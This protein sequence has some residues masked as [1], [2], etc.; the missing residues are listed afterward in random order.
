LV[1]D[2]FS[3]KNF[4]GVNPSALVTG[5]PFIFSIC[6]A[7]SANTKVPLVVNA[8]KCPFQYFSDANDRALITNEPF[9]YSIFLP[10]VAHTKV[11]WVLN[12]LGDQ[13]SMATF[14]K[15]PMPVHW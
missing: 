12:V 8:L 9:A 11:L 10:L 15:M 3:E 6:F 7:L 1:L 14:C 4:N 5:K 2:A 13:M